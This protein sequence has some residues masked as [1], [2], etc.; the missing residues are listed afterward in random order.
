MRCNWIDLKRRLQRLLLVIMRAGH[1]K[2]KYLPEPLLQEL[3]DFFSES[4]VFHLVLRVSSCGVLVLFLVGFVLFLFW[5]TP[6]FLLS[7]ILQ[8]V[9]IAN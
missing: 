3:E 9:G 5:K 1:A 6:G 2:K 7:P 4:V 8:K